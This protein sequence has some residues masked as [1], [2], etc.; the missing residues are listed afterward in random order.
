MAQ[1]E[2]YQVLRPRVGWNAHV[3]IQPKSMLDT[4]PA[5]AQMSGDM[6]AYVRNLHAQGYVGSYT[7]TIDLRICNVVYNLCLQ[8]GWIANHGCIMR[9]AVDYVYD[10]V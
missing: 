2:S 8:I 5:Y 1:Y 9:I 6:N 7:M 4:R 3:Q 10:I